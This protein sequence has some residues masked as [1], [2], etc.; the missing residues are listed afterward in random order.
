MSTYILILTLIYRSGYG[1][2]GG[3]ETIEVSTYEQCQKIGHAWSDYIK[4]SRNNVRSNE[5]LF[6]C[7]KKEQ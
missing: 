4:R 1:G 3:I 6:T 7:I 5:V 2:M